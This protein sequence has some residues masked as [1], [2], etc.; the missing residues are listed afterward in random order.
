[1]I[2]D[3][4]DIWSMYQL[5]IG[6]ESGVNLTLLLKDEIEKYAKYT[7]WWKKEMLP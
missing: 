4:E 2:I 6:I 7:Q 5:I 1:M 3:D